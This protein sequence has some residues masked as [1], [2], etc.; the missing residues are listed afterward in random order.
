SQGDLDR[1]GII[2]VWE[3]NLMGAST[4]NGRLDP[5][6]PDTDGDGI[7][8]GKETYIGG[9]YYPGYRFQSTE[10]VNWYED[11]D[12]DGL[13]NALDLDSDDDGISD[14]QEIK[15]YEANVYLWTWKGTMDNYTVNIKHRMTSDGENYIGYNGLDPT[16]PL[17]RALDS[18]SDRLPD[19]KELDPKKYYHDFTNRMSDSDIRAQFNPFVQENLPPKIRNLKID[20]YFE[21]TSIGIDLLSILGVGAK[22]SV[23]IPTHVW[24]TVEGDVIDAS[25]VQGVLIY[26]SS[27]GWIDSDFSAMNWVEGNRE[28]V[29]HFK[30]SYH[31]LDI[32]WDVYIAGKCTIEVTAVDMLG[33][34]VTMEEQWFGVI[35]SVINKFID[36]MRGV[37]N[38]AVSL[39]MKFANFL[40]DWVV[41]EIKGMW[42][43]NTII[44]AVK[45]YIGGITT[46]MQ[47]FFVAINAFDWGGTSTIPENFSVE[48][49]TENVIDKGFAFMTSF[50]GIN[51]GQSKGLI[52]YANRLLD[53]YDDIMKFIGPFKYLINPMEAMEGVL[54][55]LPGLS[56]IMKKVNSFCTGAMETVVN[57]MMNVI[58][59]HHN[60][61]MNIIGFDGKG[62]FEDDPS[63]NA[64]AN[65]ITFSGLFGEDSIVRMMVDKIDKELKV[66]RTR[67]D[68][69][70]GLGIISLVLSF[71]AFLETFGILSVKGITTTN[72]KGYNVPSGLEYKYKEGVNF[73]EWKG[74]RNIGSNIGKILDMLCACISLLFDSV[75]LFTDDE[76]NIDIGEY[77][78][79]HGMGYWSLI[80][81]TV[82]TIVADIVAAIKP[83]VTEGPSDEGNL[84]K[85]VLLAGANIMTGIGWIKFV[86]E[87]NG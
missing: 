9:C 44:D 86:K 34:R 32:P 12:G 11:L 83:A 56:K 2:N 45:G 36:F 64:V 41:S 68:T 87:C 53:V 23:D 30:N 66:V 10:N 69:W 55:K 70:T 25:G 73:N 63:Y 79:V 1:D 48:S 60:S 75:F 72:I 6:N 85:W 50:L 77:G 67:G 74:L 20:T 27:N 76:N 81:G 21:Y 17:N 8:D 62:M 18:D 80:I 46:A 33:N 43:I 61:I 3:Y 84:G 71:F 16:D 7:F 59:F 52:D 57:T 42:G 78:S 31:S 82:S 37:W 35:Q 39:A 15:G 29:F 38:K 40:Y 28:Q 49:A 19:Y 51:E 65:F 26:V 24:M 13:I 58:F 14:G 54:G 22:V 4:E 47:S 5:S